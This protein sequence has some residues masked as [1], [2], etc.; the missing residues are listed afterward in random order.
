MDN[1]SFGIT[2]ESC[3][4]DTI[5]DKGE[6]NKFIDR[7]KPEHTATPLNKQLNIKNFAIYYQTNEYSFIKKHSAFKR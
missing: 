2:L 4:I 7:R 1:F 6:I 5:N 3:R